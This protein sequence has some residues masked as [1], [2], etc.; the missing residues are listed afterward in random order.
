MQWRYVA[1]ALQ[2]FIGCIIDERRTHEL[3][4]AMDHAMTDDSNR[5]TQS[6]TVEGLAHPLDSLP[7]TRTVDRAYRGWC[8]LPLQTYDGRLKA[9]SPIDHYRISGIS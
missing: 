2:G 3:R 6:L 9:T 1:T 8:T 4:P 5:L 7:D